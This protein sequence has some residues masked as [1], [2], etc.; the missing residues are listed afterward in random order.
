[1]AAL[2]ETEKLVE[3]AVRH[4]LSRPCD[5]AERR[6][7]AAWFARQAGERARIGERLVW[8]LAASAEFRFV[9]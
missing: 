6:E 2:P 5:A 4:V 1:L 7:L 9:P 3:E 8:A